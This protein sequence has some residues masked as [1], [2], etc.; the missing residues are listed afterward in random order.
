MIIIG[1]HLVGVKELAKKDSNYRL[2]DITKFTG[3]D[4][5]N[6]YVGTA[7][8]F[9]D[10][11]YDVIL[12]PRKEVIEELVNREYPVIMFLPSLELK[13]EWI[14]KAIDQFHKTNSL[15]DARLAR[16]IR[17]NFENDIEW[18]EI[19]LD[20]SDYFFDVI[21][22]SMNYDLE[23][24][25]DSIRNLD[26]VSHNRAKDV[27]VWGIGRDVTKKAT[28]YT[29]NL[30]SLFRE[31]VTGE[32]YLTVDDEIVSNESI[33]ELVILVDLLK[34][35]YDRS[36][37]SVVEEPFKLSLNDMYEH[38]S[39]TSGETI[40]EIIHKMYAFI[41]SLYGHEQ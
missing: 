26:F 4:W 28:A 8:I 20:R 7:G 6:D 14:Q 15:S 1:Y 37:Y 19:A 41:Y 33:D 30:I 5:V 29:D 3:S 24:L 18:L 31:K 11:G 16:H 10:M 22:D 21:L 23:K 25:L 36:Q 13:D 35:W 38:L 2:L 12:E 9:S 40:G 34:Q 17:D 39:V 32:Y 27:L